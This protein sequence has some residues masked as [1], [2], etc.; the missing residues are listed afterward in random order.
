MQKVFE[1]ML[2]ETVEIEFQPVHQLRQRAQAQVQILLPRRSQPEFAL[3]LAG[4]A[5]VFFDLAWAQVQHAEDRL[6]RP[7]NLLI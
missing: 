5:R 1:Q 3:V 2:E 6:Q 7:Q 4:D